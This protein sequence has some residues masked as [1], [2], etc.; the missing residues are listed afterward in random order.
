M[1][2]D[3][4]AIIGVISGTISLLLGIFNAWHSWSRD[5]VKLSVTASQ[6]A[7]G[8]AF[9]KA[10]AV[11]SLQ[12]A[13]RGAFAVSIEDAGIIFE[14]AEA[15]QIE[16]G[17]TVTLGENTETHSLPLRLKPHQAITLSGGAPDA[18]IQQSCP[19][20]AYVKTG[21]GVIVKGHIS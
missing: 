5:R 13:N 3:T 14:K 10:E 16:F 2:T 15:P 12:V 17:E 1:S 4:L 21:S 18:A 9:G 7:W 11:F 20:Y 19:K 8:G 6:E